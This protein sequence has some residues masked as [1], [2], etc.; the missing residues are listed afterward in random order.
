MIELE[1]LLNAL[2]SAIDL[3]NA[4]GKDPA[5]FANQLDQLKSDI[6]NAHDHC[7]DGDCDHQ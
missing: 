1:L 4:T 7:C 5:P 6:A 3:C 2:E